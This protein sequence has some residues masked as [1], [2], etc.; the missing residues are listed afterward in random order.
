MKAPRNPTP[1]DSPDDAVGYGRPP[2]HSRFK[3]GNSGNPSGR[4]KGKKRQKIG[5]LFSEAL[6]QRISVREGDKLRKISRA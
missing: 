2:T 3:A 6:G 4:P 1:D 5:A